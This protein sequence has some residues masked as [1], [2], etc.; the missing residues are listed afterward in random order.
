M[1]SLIAYLSQEEYTLTFSLEKEKKYS[2]SQMHMFL[3]WL[4]EGGNR[5]KWYR[6][7]SCQ[8]EPSKV[9]AWT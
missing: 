9:P 4:M 6:K 5:H 7:D 3:N 2:L 8:N 1:L